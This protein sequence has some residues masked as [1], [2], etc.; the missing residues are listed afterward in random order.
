[1]R[2]G[3]RGPRKARV[4]AC[5]RAEHRAPAGRCAHSRSLLL[6]ARILHVE[7][8]PRTKDGR[9]PSRGHSPYAWLLQVQCHT[10]ICGIACHKPELKEGGWEALHARPGRTA[11]ACC[12]IA[13][14]EHKRAASPARHGRYRPVI[15]ARPASGARASH[16][17]LPAAELLSSSPSGDELCFEETVGAPAPR[18]THPAFKMGIAGAMRQQ[19]IS[20]RAR[21]P[22]LPSSVQCAASAGLTAVDAVMASV[23]AC[24]MRTEPYMCSCVRGFRVCGRRQHPAAGTSTMASAGP[25]WRNPGSPRRR[26][27]SRRRLPFTAS[28]CAPIPRRQWRCAGERCPCITLCLELS[29]VQSTG[30]DLLIG[31]LLKLAVSPMG[32]A[33]R[34]SKHACGSKSMSAAVAPARAC[35]EGPAM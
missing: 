25:W 29:M 15:K 10:R 30:G 21:I 16:A 27:P 18:P 24:K 32:R 5:V 19:G 28:S 7:P 13:R 35:C 31:K 14:A 11:D 1:M 34:S 20:A 6:F 3:Q 17:L 23:H 12:C 2:R 22:S 4:T 33:P 26:L 8:K 9:N